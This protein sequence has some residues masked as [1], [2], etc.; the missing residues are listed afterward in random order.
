[1]CNFVIRIWLNRGDFCVLSSMEDKKFAR[2][3]NMKAVGHLTRS[4][5]AGPIVPFETQRRTNW[6][7]KREKSLN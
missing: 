2:Y 1:M 6:R 3:T 5:T 7:K 4:S